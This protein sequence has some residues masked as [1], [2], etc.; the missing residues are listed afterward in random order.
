[1][2]GGANGLSPIENLADRQ[3]CPLHPSKRKFATTASAKKAAAERSKETGLDIG[4]YLCEGCGSYHLTRNTGGDSITLVEGK[5]TVGEYRPLDHPAFGER[6]ALD[7]PSPIPGDHDTRVRFMRAWLAERPGA[8]PTSTE[9][10]EA[11]ACSNDTVRQTMRAL[12]YRNT[13]GRTARWIEAEPT[14]E[15]EIMPQDAPG[16][17]LTAWDAIRLESIAHLSIGDL[18][19]VYGAAGIEVRLQVRR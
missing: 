18:L 4:A 14:P 6:P 7:D 13:G 11:L 2:S 19:A 9:I 3:K 1:M 8:E 5:V 12:G 10:R 15:P 17:D 16:R